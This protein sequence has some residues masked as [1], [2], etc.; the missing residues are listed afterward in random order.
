MEK[1]DKEKATQ[2]RGGGVEVR[3]Q[4]H[5][6][7]MAEYVTEHSSTD[8]TEHAARHD[9]DRSK[10]KS[11][12][13]DTA[14]C[15][16][17]S[18]SHCI[19]VLYD[20]PPSHGLWTEEEHKDSHGDA[21]KH[22]GVIAEY[23]NGKDAEDRITEHASSASDCYREND[24]TKEIE[25]VPYALHCASDSED[26]R[27]EDIKSIDNAAV[28]NAI[29]LQKT[30]FSVHRAIAAEWELDYIQ[31]MGKIRSAWEIAL[32][33]TEGIQIDKDKLR[34]SADVDKAR[35]S[36]GSFLSTDD[37]ISED[38]LRNEL[39][40]L[41]KA[42]VKE[43]LAATIEANLSL[44]Q[45]EEKDPRLGKVR[46]LL[47]IASSGDANALGLFDEIEAFM[48]RY[49]LHRK[50]LLEKMK[51][52]Y[53]PV[54]EE[55]SEKLSKQY[56]TEVHLSFENDKEFMEAVRQ[57]LERLEAQYQSTLA[58]AKAQLKEMLNA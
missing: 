21:D 1:Q 6:D 5:R 23:G 34:Y 33:R 9:T 40:S 15:R 58:N 36:A 50:D 27:T 31:G 2:D 43:G 41:D 48:E 10:A 35:R 4:H 54:L 52:Q 18:Q 24:Y 49:P 19:E 37:P 44:P 26:S 7:L 57:N 28:H 3:S 45:S 39:S 16:E 46:T 29:R 13:L 17:Y 22:I 56:G 55:K 14:Y 51:A 11:L 20:G 25:P 47:G 32:E 53:K 12:R 30:P 42:A 8:R 38:E